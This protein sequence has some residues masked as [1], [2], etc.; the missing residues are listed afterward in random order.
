MGKAF[1]NFLRIDDPV[2]AGKLFH[3]ETGVQVDANGL[4]RL[5]HKLAAIKG[6]FGFC[7]EEIEVIR[8][9]Q[10]CKNILRHGCAHVD[11]VIV[12]IAENIQR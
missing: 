8:F 10:L 7:V 4:I 2:R 5:V 12:R 6:L 1:P 11:F 3:G 9:A